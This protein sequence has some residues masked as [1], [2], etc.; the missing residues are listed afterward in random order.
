MNN[1]TVSLS[2]FAA[3]RASRFTVR[4]VKDGT[5]RDSFVAAAA[6]ETNLECDIL[7]AGGL[8]PLILRKSRE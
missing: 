3:Y 5:S 6:I 1:L 2:S 8:L 7:R 4:I